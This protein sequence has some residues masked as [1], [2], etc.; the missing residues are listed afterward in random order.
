QPVSFADADLGRTRLATAG[1]LR[2]GAAHLVFERRTRRSPG[3][4]FRLS[5]GRADLSAVR[6]GRS[7]GL[8]PTGRPADH[9]RGVP[10][11]VEDHLRALPRR[12][13]GAGPEGDLKV[14]SQVA[15]AVPDRSCAPGPE[16][17]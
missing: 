1:D 3:P 14:R 12:R 2:A 17:A 15:S 9:R 8:G 13:D 11:R 4:A 5:Q 7:A 10:A 6:P 16:G